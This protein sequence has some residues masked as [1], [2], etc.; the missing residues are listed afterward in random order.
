MWEKTDYYRDGQ[1]I[2]AGKKRKICIMHKEAV[3]KRLVFDRTGRR[4]NGRKL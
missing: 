3:N 4:E 2:V 1:G